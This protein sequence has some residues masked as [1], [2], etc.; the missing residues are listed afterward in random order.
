MPTLTR[1]TLL[2]DDNYTK[3]MNWFGTMEKSKP[4]MRVGKLD[5]AKGSRGGDLRMELTLEVPLLRRG[6]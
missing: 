3:L 1:A 6:P 2:F 5:L 4:T